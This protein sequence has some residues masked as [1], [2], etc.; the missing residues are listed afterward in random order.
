MTMALATVNSKKVA[1]E[2]R[3]RAFR[4]GAS[5]SVRGDCPDI[6]LPD[7]PTAKSRIW[8]P[9]LWISEH[10]IIGFEHLV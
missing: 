1:A 6:D 9:N 4:E 3:N 8:G 10:V 7:D 5:R 2:A